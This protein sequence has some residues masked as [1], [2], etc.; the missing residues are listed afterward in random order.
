MADPCDSD[1]P[2]YDFWQPEHII[3]VTLS[4]VFALVL[5]VVLVCFVRRFRQVQNA[6][7]SCIG[8]MEQNRLLIHLQVVDES[9]LNLP[10]EN[11]DDSDTPTGS[12][13]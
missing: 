3:V 6:P 2:D 9:L 4:A 7:V 12:L 1:E 8:L 5:V 11:D 13:Y 10:D